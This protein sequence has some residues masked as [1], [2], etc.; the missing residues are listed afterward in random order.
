MRTR[1]IHKAA[2]TDAVTPLEEAGK[3]IAYQAAVEGIVLLE[4]DG[5][6]PLKPGKIALY[7]A[8]AKMTIKGGTGSGEVNERHAVSILEGMEDAGFKITTMNWIDDYDQSFQEGE[9]AYAEEFRK[10]LSPKNLSDFMNLMSSPYRY[11]YG[12]AVLQEDVEKSE[13]DTCIYV[14]SRQAGEGADRKLSENEYGL[15]EIERVNLTFCAEQYEHM[16]VVINVGGQFDLNFLH[17]IPSINA[18]IFMGQ[19]GTMGGQAVADIVCGKHTPSGKLTDTWAKHYRDYPA[20]DDYSYLNG[21]LDEEYY[22]EGIYVGYRY[23]DT[24]HVAP[25]Y[26]FGYGLSY[27]EFEMHLAGMRLERTTVEI[28][29]DVKNKGEVYSGKEVVQIYVSCPDGE[30]KKEAQRLTSFAKTK[31]LKPGEEERTVLQFDLRD[32]ISYLNGNLDEEY[33]REGI[34]V[35]YRYF[36]TFHVAP[37]YPFGYGLSY[38]EFEMHLAGMRLERTTVEIS[39]DVKNK[40]E[41][42]SGKEVV[43]I[44]VSCPDGELKKEAQRLTSFAK[45]KNLKPGEEERTVLQFDL[46]DLIS[47]RE[48][49]TATVLEP[50]EYVVRIGNSSRNTRVCGILKLETEMITEKH[51]HI[52]K[53]PLRVTELE[54]QEEKELLHATGDCRQ[55]WGR[56]CEII[57]DDVEKIQSFQI[58][59]GIIPEVDHEYGPVEIYSSEETDRILESL[60]L[61]DMAELVVGGGMSGHRF[62]EAP[63]AAGVTTGNLTAKGIPNVVMADGPAGL[64]L[65]KISSVSITGKVKG[66]EPNISFMKY[67]PEPV[68]KVMLGNPDSK[69]LLYQFTTAFPVGISLASS[70]NLQLAEEVGNA[71]GKEMEAY[72]VTYWLAPGMNIHRN[73]LCGRNFEYFSEDPLLTGKFAAAITKGV[74]KNRGC[75]VTLKHYCC[76]NQEDNRNKTNANVNERALREIYLKGFE[77]AVKESHPGAVMSSYNKVNG[78]YVNNSYR[79]L[80]QVLRNEWGFDGF[81]MTDWFATGRKYGDPAHAIASGNDLIMPGSSGTVDDIVKAVSKGIILEEDVKRSAAN[82]L[83]GIISSRIYQGYLRKQRESGV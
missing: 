16:I 34:Y 6:L 48:K 61:R 49:D 66:I 22:R 32:L 33:Y 36:D 12:R 54:W 1:N 70:W 35:G 24:F 13:T 15:A 67:L 14:I 26:P 72:G 80:T 81:V 53:A 42:Y 62:F 83:K 55:N 74:Q 21:N 47:Y 68:K 64:R 76:N 56:T 69:N 9:R 79:L 20:S 28:S 51:S 82:V 25:R 73:P 52:C 2:L 60:T 23:F 11:P 63:G 58:E 71:V 44:Y 37:R 4:N 38:T 40:G 31:N 8:G 5:C 45:T 59:P 18:V 3:E 19:L 39:V 29:V 43:Q 78:K 65:H 41:V 7:G 30:L 75:Y 10:K 77:I 17:E 27:T 50:G 46:R 57:I